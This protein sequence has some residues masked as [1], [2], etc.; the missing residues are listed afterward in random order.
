MKQERFLQIWGVLA[1]AQ[2]VFYAVC[3]PHVLGMF[4]HVTFEVVGNSIG[5][6]LLGL[7]CWFG[8]SWLYGIKDEAKSGA[9]KL[10]L[11]VTAFACLIVLG[12]VLYL[13]I[14]S[15]GVA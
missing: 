6:D 8:I 4:R 12:S 13:N 5:N 7:G 1:L 11:V 10:L 14:V 2:I 15:L 9:K 3:F